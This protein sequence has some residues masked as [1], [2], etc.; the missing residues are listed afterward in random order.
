MNRIALLLLAVGGLP[1]IAQ[2][3]IRFA[4]T[5]DISPSGKMV[6]FSY[7][8]DIWTVEAIGGVA[9]PITM[10]EAH[11]I[12]PCFS[13]DGRW[14]AFSSNR[15]GQYDVFVTHAYGGKP[16]RLTFD[17]A[18][19]M[20]VGW[21]PDGKSILFNSGRGSGYP[22]V[23][24]LYSVPLD[25][26]QEVKLPFHE[27]KDVAYSPGGT[28]AAFVRGP[29]IWYRKSYR[30]S[31]NDDIWLSTPDGNTVKQLTVFNGQDTS[32]MW[33]ADGKK[34]FY[35][36]EVLGN[37][38]NILQVDV[39]TAT[40]P[41]TPVGVAK[42]LT[43]H[44]DDGVRRAKI[45]GNGEWIVYECGGD[46]WIVS[47]KD[48]S[49]RK[50]AIEVHADEKANADK[51]T[52][53]SRD[54]SEYALSPDENNIAFVVH[55]EVFAMPSKGGK[56]NRLTETP[57]VEHGLSWS[58][59]NKKLIFTS[60]RNGYEE[61]YLLESDD[62]DTSDLTKAIRTK[63]KTLT[64]TPVAK[65]GASFSPDGS[66]IAFLQNGKLFTMKSDG[67]D[68]KVLVDQT[69]V[70]D[71]DWSPDGKWMVYS[72]SDGSFAS[73]LYIMP[74]NGDKP[75]VNVTRYATFNADVNWAGNK[76]SFMSQRQKSMGLYVLSLQKPSNSG[77]SSSSTTTDID[78][79]DLHLRA[80]RPGN[81][82]ASEGVI[83]KN[84]K[85]VAFRG[86]SNGDDLWVA[87]TD[88]GSLNRITTGNTAPHQ[89]RWTK[90]GTVYFLDNAGS[91]RNVMPSV[92]TSPNTVNFTAKLTI[93]R[94]EE[95][96]EI[97]D[98]SW[99]LLSDSFYDSKHHGVN[100]SDVR[101]KYRALVP[102][103]GMKED[104]YSLISLMLGELNASHLGISG[105]LRS[106]DEETAELGLLFDEAY[107]GPGMK[108]AE[109]I[110]RGPADKRGI[111]LKAGDIITSVDRT[112]LT[113]K[114]NLS[115][116]LNTKVNENVLLEVAG[117]PADLKTTRKL[118]IHATNRNRIS[119]L[120][121]ERWVEKN[122]E[123]VSKASGGKIGYI[124]IPSMDETG[125][126]QFV[127]SLYS[128]NF[129]KEA[130][131][132]DVR[133]NGGGFTHDQVLNYLGAK[134]HTMFRQRDGGEGLVM[135]NFDRK[136]TKPSAVLINNRS[137]SDAEIFPSAYRS[138]GYGKV[139][140]QSTGG[141]VIGTTSTRLI[142]GSQFR[143]PR[144]GVFTVKGINMEKEGVP[145][146]IA[147]EALPEDVAKGYDAQLAKAAEVL[148]TEVA[149]WKK[150]RPG[151]SGLTGVG[152]VPVATPMK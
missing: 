92:S 111:S 46:L 146:D 102:H 127:R 105:F 39:N 43:K 67:T 114:T 134:E 65:I 57:G 104:L 83:S 144:T 72:R 26:G 6:T 66:R 48:G 56:A 14:I 90:G 25:G 140:G 18:N 98:Q 77:S 63:V 52:T 82:S 54:V 42:Q 40:N 13:P 103:V 79:E 137:Y 35:V 126:E 5:P 9:R 44:I 36:S 12:F 29:G 49:S 145:P 62:P 34:L 3:P 149:E 109:V 121:Y 88:G 41:P 51:V 2:E 130:I 53:Y 148:K 135:R 17:S 22:S 123:A 107:R 78:W 101:E 150:T 122:A 64:T 138:L 95:Y 8:G 120:L 139:I 24:E 59:D 45:S 84:G 27:A 132:I 97:F 100:W 115:Q 147:V 16:R 68:T 86:T 60:D 91:I 87:N 30:G 128:D 119:Q 143:L 93:R 94:D 75:P 58:P 106:P 108:I 11:E 142:D 4:R 10:H 37:P 80:D 74:L 151:G 96:L 21:S 99:R 32:P 136:W 15:H 133:Y 7:L 70:F 125:L 55:G 131:I 129:D 20:V 76:I 73:E 141:L 23:P 71:Y 85:Q 61:L 50:I 33:S 124:H 110:K 112:T 113:D 31:S 89:I 116:L 117:N 118:E 69:Q 152:V 47:V 38:A 19:D 81:I 1:L 28:A